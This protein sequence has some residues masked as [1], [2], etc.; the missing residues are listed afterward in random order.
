MGRKKGVILSYVMMVLEVLS[1]LLI[2]PFLIRTL[3]QAE[4]GVYKLSASVTAYLLLLD[5]GIGNA[6]IRYISKYRA[7]K[8]RESEQKFF[9]VSILFYLSI[10]VLALLIG[11]VLWY[12]YPSMF[13]KGLTAEEIG[14]FVM[15][16]L[17]VGDFRQRMETVFPATSAIIFVK[18]NHEQTP[19]LLK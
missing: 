5:L 4:Y 15:K 16:P 11:G 12:V 1:T 3:G 19:S 13:S 17:T 9:G 14:S 10:A 18:S 6:I 8:D 7:N 2:T